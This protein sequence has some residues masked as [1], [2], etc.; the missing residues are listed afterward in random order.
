MSP[1]RLEMQQKLAMELRMAPHIIQS[2]EVLTLPALELHTFIQEQLE[3][4]PVLEG[5]EFP[6]DEMPAEETDAEPSQEQDQQ[7]EEEAVSSFENLEREDWAEYY[8]RNSIPKRNDG[9]KD[10]KLEAM[11]NTPERPASL[12]DYL[13]EQFQLLDMTQQSKKF[14]EY[15]VYNI[16]SKGYLRYPLDEILKSAS[17]PLSLEEAEEVLRY[18]Q[19]MDPRGVGARDIQECL[20]LQ[21]DQEDPDYAFQKELISKYLLDIYNNRYPKISKETG[22]SMDDIKRTVESIQKLNPKPGSAYSTES[23]QFIVPDVMVEWIDGKYVTRLERDYVPYLRINPLY[24]RT[25]QNFS[26]TPGSPT[27]K[28]FIKKKLES[29]NWVMDAIKQRQHT[30]R[31]VAE[32]IVESQQD[33]LEHGLTHLKP[34]KMQDIS[35]ELQIHVST[36]SRAIAEKYIQTPRGIFPLKFFFT[37]SI[38]KKDGDNESRVTVQE[39]IQELVRQEDKKRPLSDEEIADKLQDVGLEIARRTVTKYRKAMTIPSSRRRRQY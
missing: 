11:Q 9:E 30:L 28:E 36:V 2:I 21:L 38:D 19:Q 23:A 27:T 35:N 7:V 4:N 24:L 15:L 29:A 14:G 6:T 32:K 8:A 31:R 18:I 26:E 3:M 12:Q 22:R 33:F 1:M 5:G 34:L 20:I 13:L 25:L 17:C 10:A 39:R 16:D 37:G